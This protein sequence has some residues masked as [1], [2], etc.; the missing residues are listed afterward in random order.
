ME[1]KGY[2][3]QRSHHPAT[4]GNRKSIALQ[5]EPWLGEDR[6]IQRADTA[7]KMFLN[8]LQIST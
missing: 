4:L 7:P 3:I 5:T 1:F 6:Y 8:Y 2:E